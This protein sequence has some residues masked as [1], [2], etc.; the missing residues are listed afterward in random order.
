MITRDDFDW[1]AL[2]EDDGGLPVHFVLPVNE[3]G[4]G[5][6]DDH[7]T[8]HYVCWCGNERCPLTLVLALSWDAG[9]RAHTIERERNAS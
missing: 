8:H 1:R 5:P 4:Q 9:Q 6:T 7:D 3:N 2:G